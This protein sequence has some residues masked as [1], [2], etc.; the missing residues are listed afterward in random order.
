[1][2]DH[3]FDLMP[4]K[5]LHRIQHIRVESFRDDITNNLLSASTISSR[6]GTKPNWAFLFSSD[7]NLLSIFTFFYNLSATLHLELPHPGS[8]RLNLSKKRKREL[9]LVA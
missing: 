2:S 5:K 7:N 4:V 6:H 3:Y 8:V 1:V 9:L